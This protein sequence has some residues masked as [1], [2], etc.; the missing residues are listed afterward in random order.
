MLDGFKSRWTMPAVWAASR[1]A[2]ICCARAMASPIGIGPRAIRSASVALD[3]RHHEK[4]DAVLC[5]DV[6]SGQMFRP[7]GRN[8]ARFAFEAEQGRAKRRVRREGP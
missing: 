2:A 1:P 4:V 3:E 7:H 5:A 8:R 6:V